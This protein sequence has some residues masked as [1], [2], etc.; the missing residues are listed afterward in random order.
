MKKA[1]LCTVLAVLLVLMP[2]CG[3]TG[4]MSEDEMRETFRTLI[5][6]SYEL[7][8]IYYGEGLPYDDDLEK[9]AYLLGV[10]TNLENLH[11][12]YMP[13]A[14]NAPYQTET[15]IREATAAVYSDDMCDLLFALAFEGMST[16]DDE[17]VSYARYIE[18]SGVLTVRI[19]LADD[20]LPMGRT[21]DFSGMTVI[22]ERSG[23]I[24]ASFPTEIDGKKSVDVKV[25]IIKTENGWRLDSPTY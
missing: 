7:N 2:S 8:N 1:I 17:T 22:S 10:V 5:E 3:S 20:A 14:E 6:A 12:S 4:G 9:M 16:D 18:Q 25:T 11:V 24:R 23:E 15:E 13:V 19:D 21:F